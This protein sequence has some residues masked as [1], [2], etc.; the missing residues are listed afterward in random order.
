MAFHYHDYHSYD[1]PD[2]FS[3][4]LISAAGKVWE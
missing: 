1:M 3:K 2:K 4:G